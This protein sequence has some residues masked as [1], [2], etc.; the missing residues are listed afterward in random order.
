MK[1]ID[2]ITGKSSPGEQNIILISVQ[3]HLQ[4]TLPYQQSPI[5]QQSK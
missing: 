2:I 5:D 1:G 3:L 4:K